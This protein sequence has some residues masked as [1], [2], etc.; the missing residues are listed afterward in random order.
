MGFTSPDVII[1][2]HHLP[3][4]R[5]RN[6]NKVKGSPMPRRLKMRQT[7]MVKE[8]GTVEKAKGLWFKERKKG[9]T[10]IGFTVFSNREVGLENYVTAKARQ[11]EVFEHEISAEEWHEL[12]RNDRAEWDKVVGTGAICVLDVEGSLEIRNG[13]E[14]DRIISSRMVRRWKSGEQ[15]GDAD[16]M[17]RADGA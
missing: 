6:P 16:T 3:R 11:G 9:G 1:R 4:G 7:Y 10:W 8:D 17:R 14:R 15:P 12:R 13:P 5:L 2:R